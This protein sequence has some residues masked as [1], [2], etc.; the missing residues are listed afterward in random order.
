M[1]T[2]TEVLDAGRRDHVVLFYRDERELAER[3]SEYL[4][5]VI[6]DGGVAIVLATADH[7]RSFEG[8]LANAGVDVAA[9]SAR[10]FYLAPEISET[11]RGFMV[12]N[13][14]DPASFWQTISP[15]LRQAAKTGIRSASSARWSRCCGMPCD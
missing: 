4:L 5:P 3:V 9:A 10:G 15:L 8:H 1:A 11:M 6:Q 7:C 2:G 14:P 12:A 13:W